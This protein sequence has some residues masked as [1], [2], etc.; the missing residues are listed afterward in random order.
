VAFHN[1]A[2]GFRLAGEA[3]GTLMVNCHAWGV[4]QDVSFDFAAPAISA[5]NCYADIDGGVGLRISRSDCRWIGGLILGYNHDKPNREIGVQFV[6][7][8]QPEEPAGSV[9]DTKIINCGTAAVDFGADR[10]LSSVRATLSLPGVR[11][12]DGRPVPATGLG[13]LGSPA[14]TTLVEITH[15]LGHPSKN[16]VIRPAFDLRTQETPGVPVAGAVRL[17]ARTVGGSTQLCALF[18]GGVVRVLASE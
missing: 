4:T 12:E 18:P 3:H 16:L 6:P 10:G 14:P 15:G 8:N 11:D 7:G 1:E 2:V 17:F 5:M 13:W 9:I